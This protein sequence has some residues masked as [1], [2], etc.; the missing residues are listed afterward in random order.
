MSSLG[1]TGWSWLN[2][3]DQ[4]Y[5]Q[6]NEIHF[7]LQKCLLLWNDIWLSIHSWKCFDCIF[8]L[9]NGWKENTTSPAFSLRMWYLQQNNTSPE[10]L[11][12]IFQAEVN[13]NN[14][15]IKI[16]FLK[17]NL[18]NKRIKQTIKVHKQRY[19]MK[20]TFLWTKSVPWPAKD[21]PYCMAMF[22]MGSLR[23]WAPGNCPAPGGPP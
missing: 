4:S 10:T 23:Y 21:C 13:N 14:K 19:V 8:Y 1:A 22:A 3:I 20:L 15:W 5:K 12:H 2:F 9:Q 18:V 11:T 17:W 7:K 6:V 16:Q